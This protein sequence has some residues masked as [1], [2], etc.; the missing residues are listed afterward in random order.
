MEKKDLHTVRDRPNDFFESEGRTY[1]MEAFING[2]RDIVKKLIIE[3][4]IDYDVLDSNG[5]NLMH[6]A[7]F[8][9]D[10]EMVDLM[11]EKNV[12]LNEQSKRGRTALLLLIEED[13]PNLSFIKK[14]IDKG[15]DINITDKKGNLPLHIAAQKHDVNTVSFILKMTSK[16]DKP[17]HIGMRPLHYAVEYNNLSV[18]QKIMH[19]RVD[20][21]A[22]NN[23]G[24]SLLHLALKNKDKKIIDNILKTDAVKML[25]KENISN[26]KTPF[27]Q[28][29][30][31][32]KL[33]IVHKMISYGASVNKEDGNQT[34]PLII[35]VRNDD[36]KMIEMLISSGADV[37][38]SPVL[39]ESIT[40][41]R[42][43]NPLFDTLM[44]YSPD[45]N[46]SDSSG[47]TPLMRAIECQKETIVRKLIDAGADIE[48][49]TANN[50]NAL[51]FIGRT[52]FKHLIKEFVDKGLDIN[53]ENSSGNTALQEMFIGAYYNDDNVKAMVDAGADI[54]KKDSRGTTVLYRS[55]LYQPNISLAEWLINKGAD[56]HITDNSDGGTILQLA[57]G[58]WGA[59]RGLLQ[60]IL[61]DKNI[62]V[63]AA[64]TY[65]S[66]ALHSAVRSYQVENARILLEH[67][68]DPH[69][70]DTYGSSAT[71]MADD[72]RKLSMKQLFEEYEEKRKKGLL[73]NFNKTSKD[74]KNI[75]N[76]KP[77]RGNLGFFGKP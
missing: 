41:Y 10:E 30:A 46:A 52:D 77:P 27:H 62:D 9:K 32:K 36:I 49:V 37:F 57:S 48:R 6:Y 55:L 63:N 61:S 18:V 12:S 3:N 25:N 8:N 29:V 65:G 20:V 13:E 5:C 47:T 15:A 33:D 68:A 16:V 7:A 26:Q 24:M 70:T 44:K 64:D 56:I 75:S 59:N 72:I 58:A 28:A 4:K 76:K 50:K 14:L 39:Y 73:N 51:F 45:I 11:L 17:N 38:N 22:T 1:A 53:H 54:N 43:D 34:S 21:T 67:G 74:A 31:L 2:H 23:E 66:T 71:F 40:S 60:K 19:Y 42:N 35:A 69:I